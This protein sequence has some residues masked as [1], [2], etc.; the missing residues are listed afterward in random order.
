MKIH[1]FA[2]GQRMPAWVNAGYN[3]YARRLPRECGLRLHE[4]PAA[5]RAKS[6]PVKRVIEEEGR[7]LLSQLPATA[8]TVAL[9]V[10][11][12]SWTTE[13]L[14]AMLRGWLQDGQD[15]ALLVGGPE[16]LSDECKQRA[17]QLWS[18]SPLTLPHP[19]VRVVVAEAFY[20]AWSVL[21]NHPYHRD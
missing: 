1:L 5:K 20:R 15:I 3:E 21:Q 18:L 4:I 13:Q 17:R 11:G 12:Q 8:Y 6:V 19:L 16:G 10:D 9:D 2:I 7:T 14:A